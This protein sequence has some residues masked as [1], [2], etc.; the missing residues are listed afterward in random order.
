MI[1]FVVDDFDDN[2]V[3]MYYT[4]LLML[5]LLVDILFVKKLFLV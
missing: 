2:F 3:M 1:V 5:T 4:V